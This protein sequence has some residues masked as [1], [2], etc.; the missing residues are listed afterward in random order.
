M[1][2]NLCCGDEA[3]FTI[4]TLKKLLES[5]GFKVVDIRNDGGTNIQALVEKP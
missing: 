3:G 1:K 5:I 2:L 4:P